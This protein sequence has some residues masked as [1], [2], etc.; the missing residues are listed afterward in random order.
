MTQNEPQQADMLD[1]YWTA[2]N[3]DA[4]TPPP[5][6]LDAATAAL[7]RRLAQHRYRLEPDSA[8]MAALGDRLAAQAAAGTAMGRAVPASGDQAARQRAPRRR[9]LQRPA[10]ARRPLAAIVAL[11]LTLGGVATYLHPTSP[12]PVSAQAVVQRAAAVAAQPVAPPDALIHQISTVSTALKL[13]VTPLQTTIDQWMHLDAQGNLI[14][15]A[16]TIRSLTGRL[17][18]RVLDTNGTEQIYDATGNTIFSDTLPA[19]ANPWTHDPSGM[20]SARQL[21][22][23]A[24]QHGGQN[25]RRLPDQTLGGMRVAVVALDDLVPVPGPVSAGVTPQHLT[26]TLFID[27]QTYA[28]RGADLQEVVGSTSSP[29]ISMRVTMVAAVP[30]SQA[31]AETFTLGAPATA[32]VWQPAPPR[33][34]KEHTVAHTVAQAVAMPDHPALLLSGNVAGLRFHVVGAITQSD[35]TTIT[36]YG[37]GPPV[38]VADEGDGP[39]DPADGIGS[40]SP[41]ARSMTI[42]IN[43]AAALDS[44]GQV[45]GEFTTRGAQPL[46]VTIAGQTVRATY[47]ALETNAPA[48]HELSYQQGTSWVMLSS[49]GLSKDEFFAAVAAL[50]DAR[51]HPEVVAQAQHERDVWDY[52]TRATLGALAGL[53]AACHP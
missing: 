34:V 44:A 33:V 38:R 47:W 14:E 25:A 11:L 53:C 27:P 39:V 20:A 43:H 30:L 41:R 22:V 6:A 15:R 45:P 24:Q 52:E 4:A 2:V 28:L 12:T 31:P 26:A 19:G 5:V 36:D 23:S 16:A 17:V 18:A 32:Q 49:Q 42:Q 40:P 7:A 37:Y 8:F 1:T 9:W 46:T 29:V 35:G 51:T 21:L 50:I 48:L 10:W 13:N 3:R